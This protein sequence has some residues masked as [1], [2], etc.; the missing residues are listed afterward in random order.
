[1]VRD[2]YGSCLVVAFYVFSGLKQAG[3]LDHIEK[4]TFRAFN[5]AKS[6]A[7][8]CIP[9]ITN[10][11]NFWNCLS[12]LPEYEESEDEKKLKKGF[13]DLLQIDE[14]TDEGNPYE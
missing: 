1:M 10:W 14:N 7:R 12:D 3:I 4:V 11:K 13:E 5:D 9:E 8:Y 6:V 2:I